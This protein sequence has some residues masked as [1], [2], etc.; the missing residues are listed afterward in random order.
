MKGSAIFIVLSGFI[1]IAGSTTLTGWAQSGSP[2]DRDQSSSAKASGPQ[3]EVSSGKAHDS[4]F[5]IGNN[6]VLAVSVWKEPELTKTLPVRADGK[7]TLPLV[8]EVQAAGRTPLQLEGDITTKLRNFINTP[9][10]SVLVQQVNSMNFNILGEVTKPGSYSVSIAP[11]VMD[12]IAAA[13]GFRDFAKK[14]G[15]YVLRKGP[16]GQQIRLNFNYKEFV[17]GKNP[18]QNVKLQPNDSVIVP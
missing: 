13:G 9:E 11:T 10:V 1:A 6:D 8:G 18:E 17:K 3:P 16:D 2:S 7:I 5:V 12:A 14:S 15:V 4:S